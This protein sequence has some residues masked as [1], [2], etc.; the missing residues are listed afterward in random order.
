MCW[1]TNITY[2][3]KK[4]MYCSILETYLLETSKYILYMDY[5]R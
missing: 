2:F 1:D 3:S 4:Q 5:Y